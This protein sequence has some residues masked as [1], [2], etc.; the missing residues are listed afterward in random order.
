MKTVVVTG[1]TGFIGSFLVD[2]LISK[3]YRV[4][5]LLRKKSNLERLKG[6][7]IELVEI[8]YQDMNSLIKGLK[9]VE[10]V[11][12]LTALI[13]SKDWQKL[14]YANSINTQNLVKAYNSVKTKNKN[15]DKPS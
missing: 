14:Y 15:F 4:R 7:N 10:I 3:N 5:C 6:K 13:F 2:K 11:F 1:S 8:D 9:G 12:H